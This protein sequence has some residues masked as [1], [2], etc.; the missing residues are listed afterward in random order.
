ME[1]SF[2]CDPTYLNFLTTPYLLTPEHAT[3]SAAQRLHP[4]LDYTSQNLR[5]PCRSHALHMPFA[6]R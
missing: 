4:N 1:T 2:Y 6:L 3:A 5:H